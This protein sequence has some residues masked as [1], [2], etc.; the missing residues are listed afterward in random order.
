MSINKIILAISVSLS[1]LLVIYYGMTLYPALIKSIMSDKKKILIL[2]STGGG[3]HFQ[4]SNALES[5]LKDKYHVKVCPIFQKI[6]PSIYPPGF[7][8]TSSGEDFYNSF[9][10]GKHFTILSFIYYLGRWYIQHHKKKLI[11]ILRAYFAEEKP[12]LIISVVPIINNMVLQA[13]EELTIPFLLIPTDL[14]VNSFIL[15]LKNPTYEKFHVGLM[16]KTDDIVAPLKKHGIADKHIN[17]I[18]A[19]LRKDFLEKKDKDRLKK[20]YNIDKYKLVAMVLMGSYGSYDTEK[21]VEELLKYNQPLHIFACIG[22]N[23]DSRKKLSALDIP[24]HI[25]LSIVGFTDTI[26]DYMAMSDFFISKSGTLSICEALYMN[27]PLLLDATST[28]LPWEKFNH[29]FIK[30]KGY[31]DLITEY[32]QT[33]PLLTDIVKNNFITQYK[34][35]IKQLDKKNCANQIRALVKRIIF[36]DTQ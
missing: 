29:P 14:D 25:S 9:I 10:P 6:L 33:T 11:K 7:S 17:V 30:N 22:K 16:F 1:T 18:G 23:E 27:L 34:N 26:A 35:N 31:G 24:P 12:D 19:P 5:Y 2:T 28:L 21:Y 36:Y 20:S 4:T 13:A 15:N 3:G 8:S 32:D